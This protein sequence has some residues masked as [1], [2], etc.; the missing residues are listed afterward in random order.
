M[1]PTYFT[2]REGVKV[3]VLAGDWLHMLWIIGQMGTAAKAV[4]KRLV[5]F[6]AVTGISQA[7][8]CRAI[9][10]KENRYSQYLSGERKLPSEIAVQ[11]KITYGLTT[12]WIFA[13]DVTGLPAKLHAKLANLA[14]A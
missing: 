1:Q 12:D 14:A 7:D 4:G 9:G 13:G 8:V 11:L 6:H 2:V 3:H 5:A 10:I